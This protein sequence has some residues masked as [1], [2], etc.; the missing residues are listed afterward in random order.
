M[1]F[2]KNLFPIFDKNWQSYDAYR[3]MK[4]LIMISL[5]LLVLNCQHARIRLIPSLPSQCIPWSEKQQKD[6]CQTS[7]EIIRNDLAKKKTVEKEFPQVYT[8]WG[9][10]PDDIQVDLNKE[11]PKGV[12][13]IYQYSTFMNGFY[14]Q[15]SIGFYSP[16][17]LRLTC[18]E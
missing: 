8:Y 13:E 7:L 16:R 11:C 18:Y 5:V 6:D 3:I 17:T 14:E 12:F 2:R 9:F 10:S 15:L 4:F 1:K